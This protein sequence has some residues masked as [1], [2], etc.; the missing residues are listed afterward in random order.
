MLHT[1]HQTPE[2]IGF[3]E[4]DFLMFFYV[5]Q[6]EDLL[7]KSNFRS[8]AS[9]EQTWKRTTRQ[10]YIPNFKRLSQAVLEKRFLTIF[11]FRTR[12]PHPCHRA[13]CFIP[14]IK[15]LGLVVSEKLP[16]EQSVDDGRHTTDGT[17]RKTDTGR[18]QQLTLSL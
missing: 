15:V 18:W 7:G 11:Y 9:F 10:C 8:G 13:I 16:F 5:F 4:E 14:N 1:N 2:P 17:R 6:S 3:E 12:T